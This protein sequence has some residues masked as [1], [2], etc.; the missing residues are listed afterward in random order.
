MSE[1]IFS[2][3][4]HIDFFLNNYVLKEYTRPEYTESDY[5]S[6]VKYFCAKSNFMTAIV[7]QI[8]VR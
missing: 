4:L 3:F 5:L 2:M 6:M 1:K 7:T 8:K